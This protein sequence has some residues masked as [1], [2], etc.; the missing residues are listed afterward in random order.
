LTIRNTAQ[1]P[2]WF[3]DTSGSML[4]AYIG[5]DFMVETKVTANLRSDLTQQSNTTY[6]SAGLI[7][8]DPI[9]APSKMRWLVYNIG[10][11]DG[12]FGT[13]LK[14]TRDGTGGFELEALFSGNN[15]NSTWFSNKLENSSNQAQ[16]RICRVG[17]EFR[18]LIKPTG[19]TTWLEETKNASTVRAGSN[20]EVPGLLEDA[21]I[22]LQRTDLPTVLQVGVMANT[23]DTTEGRYDYLRFQRINNFEMCSK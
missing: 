17:S 10:F 8:R 14:T 16:L 19:Q 12:Y 4:Y 18:F 1:A 11:Q 23:S 6:S 3:S 13:E 22:R 21:A 9:S 5:G 20:A 7:V 15:S 2:I